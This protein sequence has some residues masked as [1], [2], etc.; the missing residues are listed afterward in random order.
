MSYDK[1]RADI[2]QKIEAFDGEGFESLALEVFRFQVA[3][4]PL[5]GRYVSL[6]GIDIQSVTSLAQIPYLPIQFF[7]NYVVKTG[8]WQ[9]QTV[10]TSSG[11]TGAETSRHYVRDLEFY[12]RNTVQGFRQFYGN[13]SEWLVLALLPSYL[14][15]TGSSLVVM[16]E[17]FIQLSK[18]PQSGFFLNN[19]EELLN[20]LLPLTP[21]GE[22]TDAN[23][24][25]LQPTLESNSELPNLGSPLGVRGKS[26]I[27]LGV[28]F[29][30]LDLAEHY[31]LDLQH[32]TIMETGGMK[33]RRRE[34]T[35]PELH[36]QLKTAFNTTAIHSE[37]GMTELFSQ[38]YS[39]G[40]GL[41]YPARTLRASTREITDPLS[42]HQ[43]GK[44]GV[45]NLIDLANFDTCSFIATD[46][47]G[48]VFP[49][50]SFEV[51]GR[52]DNS[53]VRGCN[54]MVG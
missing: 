1:Q 19:V 22:P 35:R 25:E 38:A 46:D 18:H 52:A 24:S 9:E 4:N 26:A 13:P 5:Y 31:Q 2:L 14:E 21:K 17:H 51:L 36:G 43:V 6:L 20:V 54:L 47:L 33:G 45:L 11:T 40:D 7:K 29:A 15:R 12:K 32:V 8:E 27:L 10:F 44:T 37:Y 48:R 23:L 34:L 30:L 50:G 42:P 49:N 41:F 16:A 28:S 53:D 3:Y 39:K